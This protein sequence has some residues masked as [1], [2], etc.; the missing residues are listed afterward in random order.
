MNEFVCGFRP[1]SRIRRHHRKDVEID[2]EIER[3][4][5]CPPVPTALIANVC[6]EDCSEDARDYVQTL[7]EWLGPSGKDLDC[8]DPHR[9]IE[10]DSGKTRSTGWLENAP[11][12]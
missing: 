12:Q 6:G 7:G 9:C 3:G 2:I 5:L 10:P 11:F 8:L 1:Q 4:R